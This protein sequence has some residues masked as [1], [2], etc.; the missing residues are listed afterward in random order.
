M[1]GRSLLMIP[2]PIEFEPEVL[3]AL[4][5]PTVSH[6]APAFVEAFGV[7][8]RAMRGV[9]Q[10]PSGQP[11]IVAGSGTLA[12]ELAVASLVEP[13]DPVVVA[14][15]GVFGDRYAD[16]LGRHG[17][18]VRV[19]RASLGGTV[20]LDA[21]EDAVRASSA[22]LVVVTHVD[23]STGVRMPIHELGGLARRHGALSIVD[24]VCSV[25]GEEIRQEEWELDVVLT[26]S[27]KAIGVPPG[28]ALLVAGPRAIERFQSRSA[29]VR[30][31][32]ADWGKW[33]PVMRGYEGGQP[34][35]FGTPAVNLVAALAVSLSRILAEG[36]E[37][38][39]L[40]HESLA[41]AFQVGIEALSLEQVPAQREFRAH[42][43]SACYLP[44][45]ARPGDFVRAVEQAGVVVAGGLHPDLRERTFR[46]GHMGSV[47]PGDILSTLRA[48]E[49]GLRA[50][51]CRPDPGSGVAAAAR[52]LALPAA[53]SQCNGGTAAA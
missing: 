38:R 4:G 28:L 22:R 36:M 48:V 25:A 50:T 12:M 24:G 19:V 40:R 53:A 20:D 49:T 29:P 9:W 44:G 39:F 37:A 47:Q 1:K 33:L 8:L 31:Y 2:G 11:V 32:Y 21:L 3:E 23:T 42:T 41:R 14:S 46:V 51:G 35:Y 6:L 52:V 13:G 45:G 26:A 30:S 10:C 16:L 15:T 7:A 17:A 5:A 27:Q 43:L 18:G 34:G